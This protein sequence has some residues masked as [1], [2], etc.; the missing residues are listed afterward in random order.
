VVHFSIPING[1]LFIPIDSR[2]HQR[3]QALACQ[4]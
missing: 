2:R 3:H 1:T 4:A